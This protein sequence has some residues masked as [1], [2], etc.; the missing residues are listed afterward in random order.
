[1]R[2]LKAALRLLGLSNGSVR[3]PFLAPSDAE[4]QG[5]AQRMAALGL[6]GSA[7]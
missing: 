3:D 2:Q 1:V 7:R 6:R 5:V 4:V